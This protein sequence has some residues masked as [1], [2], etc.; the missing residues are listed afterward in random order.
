MFLRIINAPVSGETT[1]P[2]SVI[3][4]PYP[5]NWDAKLNGI[6]DRLTNRRLPPSRILFVCPEGQHTPLITAFKNQEERLRDRLRATTHVVVASY[7]DRGRVE[8]DK[9]V[10]MWQ[11]GEP[12]LVTDDCVVQLATRYTEE[13]SEQTKAILDAPSGYQFRKPSGSASRIFVRAGNMLR[14]MDSINVYS[15]MLLRQW[16]RDAKTIYIDSFTILSF[17]MALQ[18]TIAFFPDDES[19][20]VPSIENFHSYE[21]A[22][23]FNFPVDDQYL[24][25]IS[26]STSGSLAEELVSKHGA[27]PS[28]IIHL[29]GAGQDKTSTTF[30]IFKRSCIYFRK[31]ELDSSPAA[32]VDIRIGGEEFIPSYG[33]PTKISLSTRHIEEADKRRYKDEFYK[34]RLRLNS[35]GQGAGYGSYSLFSISN[36]GC[37]LGPCQ[38]ENWLIDQ[39]IHDIP[40]SISLI[41]CLADR[42]SKALAEQILSKLPKLNAVEVVQIEDIEEYTAQL[43]KSTSILIVASEDPNLEG[44]VRAA[45][46]LRKWPKAFRHFVLGHAFPETRSEFDS[47]VRSLTMRAGGERRYGWSEFAVAAIGRLDQHMNSLFNYPVNFGSGLKDPTQVEQPLSEA[48]EAYSDEDRR[49]VFLPKLDG[50]WLALRSGSVFFEGEYRGLSDEVVYLAVA[51]AIQRA[52]EGAATTDP[53][54]RFDS[55]PF[56]GSVIDPQMFSR[57]SDG[58]LQGALL[59]C[60]HPSELDFSQ[61]VALSRQVREL[62]VTVIRNARNVVGEAALEFMAALAADK[63]SLREQDHEILRKSI[64]NAGPELAQVWKMFTIQ[65]SI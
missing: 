12:W 40:A 14:E 23:S 46:T 16:P 55:N 50:G 61:S 32:L 45:T 60:L 28:R 43:P 19:T 59:R 7:N 27:N 30:K 29:I 57:F 52:R 21:K 34:L 37:V 39:L 31:L 65:S 63:I 20:D 62:F 15:H 56:V 8:N 33:E 53:Q 5:M 9:I 51:T 10:N 18:R 17:V 6:V 4:P 54:S 36:E 44:F 42:M 49:H 25:V 47:V 2:V 24:V 3:Y 35:S 11:E 64:E 13:L 1:E 26:A 38:L 48:L 22:S 58:I 41:V